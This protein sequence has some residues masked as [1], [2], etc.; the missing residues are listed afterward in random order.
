[1]INFIDMTTLILQAEEVNNAEQSINISW[2]D[3]NE[4]NRLYLLTV[5]NTVNLQWIFTTQELYLH[6]TAPEGAPPCEVY[7]LS[8]TATYVGAT[9]TGPDCSVPS[10]VITRMLP[11]L[12]LIGNVQSYSIEKRAG[13][14][15]L[16]VHFQVILLLP[17]SH[18]Q[19][20]KQS[21]CL[22]VVVHCCSHC[23]RHE[24]R[25]ILC[26]RHLCVL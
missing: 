25:Q 24:N 4:S 21:I 2:V 13:E 18:A 16:T 15:V 5:V 1:M 19:G 12:P 17:R 20:V 26:S 22:S 3:A 10:S 14:A 6:F 7:D 9:Y 8:V 23:Y 11:S